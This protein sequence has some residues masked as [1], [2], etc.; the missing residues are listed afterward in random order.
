MTSRENAANRQP[1]LSKG[2]PM[3]RASQAFDAVMPSLA[4]A[5]SRKTWHE[6]GRQFTRKYQSEFDENFQ[7]TDRFQGFFIYVVR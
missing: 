3:H 6:N 1:T 5:S 4:E 7:R 2:T